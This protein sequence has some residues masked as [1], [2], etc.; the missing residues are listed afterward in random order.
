FSS[1]GPRMQFNAITSVID[2]GWVYGSNKRLADELRTFKG[3][4]M[5]SL[6]VFK[7]FGLKDLLPLKMEDPDDGCIRPRPDIYCFHAD[8]A[9]RRA[10][11]AYA[12]DI[13][14][15]LMARDEQQPKKQV[16]FASV[17][18]KKTL[19]TG[20]LMFP[21]NSRS[22]EDICNVVHNGY[23][24]IRLQLAELANQVLLM[25]ETRNIIAA[26]I[27]HIN[28]NEFL[29]MVLGKEVMQKYDL[30]LQKDGYFNGYDPK[31]NPSASSSFVTA[32]FRFGHSL[33]PATIERWST[34][35]K[36]IGSQRL[37]ELLRQPY[38][39][40]K[41]GWCD[42]YMCGLMNQ[43]AQAMDE[44][45]TQEVTNHLFQEPGKRFGLDL[46]A[47]NMQRARE[48]GIPSYNDFREFCG[49]PRVHDWPELN[50][51]MPN[52]TV[53]RYNDVYR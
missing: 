26:L 38:D 25:G 1:T 21:A 39:L 12:E 18:R 40:Y 34:N 36:Y 35:H 43:V 44:A 5:K 52:H 16:V 2:A 37:H 33:L 46:P 9:S 31:T 10:T 11:E 17:E 41:G 3:G 51:F 24:G 49:L 20:A 15:L 50:A 32:A 8:S 48:H 23:E 47:L 45:V 30:I 6:P 13:V 42:Q 14:K 4:M 29:P 22:N 19:D 27:Q 7:E 28:Y 53:K